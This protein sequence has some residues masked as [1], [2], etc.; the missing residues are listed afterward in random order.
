MQYLFENGK[1]V[2]VILPP[3]GNA[4]KDF[5]SYRRTQKSTIM[6]IKEAAGKPKSVVSA[7][8]NAAGGLCAASSASELQRNRR[9]IY[10]SQQSSKNCS[11]KVDPIFELIQQCKVDLMPGGRKFIRCVNF[12]SSP[13]CVLASDAQLQ[14]LIKYCTIP[15]ASCVLGIDPTFNLGKFY[16]TI[17][18]FVNSHDCG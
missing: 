18:T 3:H 1:K 11:D 4:R 15:G 9:Q 12:D 13:C 17:T 7:L 5:S 14:N 10:N 8:H 6:K 16:V 2:P